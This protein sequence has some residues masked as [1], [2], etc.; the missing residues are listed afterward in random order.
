MTNR[1]IGR[2]LAGAAMLF[3]AATIALP[4][5][6]QDITEEHLAAARVAIAA[7]QSTASMDIILPNIGERLK[8]QLI[9]ARPDAAEQINA[10][11]NDATIEL[12]PRR[13][14]LEEEVARTYARIFSIEE[15]KQIEEFYKTDAGKKLISETAVIA[16][17]ME[18]ASRVWATGV[19]RDLQE[20][21]NKK[22]EE[23]GLQ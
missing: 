17:S 13:G 5:A 14:D 21:V 12:A 22:I 6:A 4:A 10:I 8:Q 1:I 18:E 19:Q 20:A 9:D 16:R 11:V 2:W 23:A 15:L 7:S 3:A